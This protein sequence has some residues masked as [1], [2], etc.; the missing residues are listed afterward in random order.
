MKAKKI[1]SMILVGAASV[2]LLAGCGAG[3]EKYT[4][5]Q[6]G[7]CGAER[8]PGRYGSG[9]HGRDVRKRRGCIRFIGQCAGSLLFGDR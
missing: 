5:G 3:T 1:L 4:A 6:Y 9:Q 2:S 8:K 7:R